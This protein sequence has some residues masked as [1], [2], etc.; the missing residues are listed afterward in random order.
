[1][2]IGGVTASTG[3][4]GGMAA[5]WNEKLLYTCGLGPGDARLKETWILDLP[6]PVP[7]HHAA[8]L[9][10]YP[11]PCSSRVSIS[12]M[13]DPMAVGWQ[14]LKVWRLDGTLLLRKSLQAGT[15]VLDTEGWSSGVYILEVTDEQGKVARG[16]VCRE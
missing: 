8:P 11:N 15:L 1:M 7:E 9:K 4:R 10:I 6:L 13:P 12:V 3:R 2:A 5:G 16:K 14:W